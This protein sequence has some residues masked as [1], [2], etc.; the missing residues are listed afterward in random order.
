LKDTFFSIFAASFYILRGVYYPVFVCFA[1]LI[2]HPTNL[3]EH[4]WFCC[5][6]WGLYLL[7]IFW[8]YLIGQMAVRLLVQKDL[9]GD[10][11]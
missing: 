3:P 10:V 5:L 6:L 2:E 8:M 4:W 1:V 9:G 11:R 7:Y